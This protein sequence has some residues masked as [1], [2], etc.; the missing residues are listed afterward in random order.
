MTSNQFFI[1]RLEDGSSLV[2]LRGEEHRHL[3]KAARVR[4]G[5]SVRLFDADGR[6]CWAEVVS[7]GRE[8]TELRVLKRDG[9]EGRRVNLALVQ[10]MLQAKKMEFLVQKAAELGCAEFLPVITERS[11]REAAERSGRKLERWSR[12]ALEATK[13]SKGALATVVRAPRP[14]K[15]YLREPGPGRRLLLSERGGRPLKDILA[16]HDAC[17]GPETPSSVILLIGP[18]GGWSVAEEG[19]ARESGFEAASLGHR[20][21]KAETAALAAAAMVLHFWGE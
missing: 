2:V 5:D 17:P 10:A 16:D 15:A 12:I 14:L 21:L 20:I 8:R 3:A 13:Q 4:P 1:P 9:T 11:L 6:R 19:L 18:E 7:V